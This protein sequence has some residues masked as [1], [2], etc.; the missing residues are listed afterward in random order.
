MQYLTFIMDINYL[1]NS[2]LYNQEVK[3][4]QTVKV[5]WDGVLS[6]K[7]NGKKY[8]VFI[9]VGNIEAVYKLR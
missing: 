3:C 6:G 8:Y 2:K 4:K 1:Y 5:R 7:H 9:C